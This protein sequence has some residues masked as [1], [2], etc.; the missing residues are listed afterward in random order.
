MAF[1]SLKK[2]IFCNLYKINVRSKILGGGVGN[3]PRKKFMCPF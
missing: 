2:A 1:C 3:K